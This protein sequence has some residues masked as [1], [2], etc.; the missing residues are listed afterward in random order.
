MK[1]LV[2]ILSLVA[3]GSIGWVACDSTSVGTAEEI[4]STNTLAELE[5]L[6][7][8]ASKATVDEADLSVFADR[9]EH[10]CYNADSAAVRQEAKATITKFQAD[11]ASLA[12]ENWPSN[13]LITRFNSLH[14]KQLDRLTTF[15]AAQGIET[16]VLSLPVGVYNNEEL[17]GLF[18]DLSQRIN[19]S[20]TEAI[21]ALGYTQELLLVLNH[22]KM[23]GK[24]AGIKAL[25]ARVENGEAT[26]CDSARVANFRELVEEFQANG[27][28]FGQRNRNNR[29]VG[30]QNPGRRKGKIGSPMLLKY[31]VKF[32]EN[33]G[34]TYEAQLLEND[35][36]DRIVNSSLGQGRRNG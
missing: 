7:E 19:A 34:I 18:A 21:F 28:Q 15:H 30:G 25:R 5:A 10:P 32:L 11:I 6:I 35:I 17:D 14:A 13:K 36:F 3:F 1:K 31:V 23:E 29:A 33:E 2:F 8:T 22:Q 24:R 4:A 26:A 16:A 9:T 12:F 20:E 27:N